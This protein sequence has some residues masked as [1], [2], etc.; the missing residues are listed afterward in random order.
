VDRPDLLGS[1]LTAIEEADL[2]ALDTETT[3][4][5]PQSDRVRLLSLGLPTNDGR[6]FACLI[7]AFAVDPSPVVA[8]LQDKEIVGHNLLFDLAF[9]ANIGF[10]PSGKL[11][12][13]MTLS[14]TLYAGLRE[15]HGLKE[16]L[17][18]ELEVEL[19][20]EMQAADWSAPLTEEHLS[21]AA[22]DVLHLPDLLAALTKKIGEAGLERTAEIEGRCLPAVCWMGSH[23][24]AIDRAAWRALAEGAEAD[25]ARLKREMAE[26]APVRPGEMFA[27]WG[28]DSA[29]DTKAMFQALGFAVEDTAD[30]TLAKIDHPIAAKLRDYRAATK[31]TGTYGRAWTKHISADGRVYP[32]WN[33]TGSEA[34]R[35]S[36]A[37]P[38]LQQIPRDRAYRRCV[39][40]PPGRVLIK[41][42]Y[43]QIELRIAAKVSG[44]KALLDA[45]MRGEDVHTQTA[46]RVLGKQNVT[47]EDR[48]LAKALNFG[49]LY[50]MGTERFRENAAAEYGLDLS[51]EQA[52]RYRDAFF[53]AYPGL[54]AWH[55]S[56]GR[57]GDAA[58][59]TRTL[60]R[61]RRVG[62]T[63][64]T[65]KLNTPVQGTGADG[66]KLAL[67][68]L[69]E[70]RDQAPGASPVLAVHDEIVVEAD[71]GRADAAAAWLK[72]AM[73]DA[74]APL[75]APVP[76]EIEV[77]VART[78][79]G[80]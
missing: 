19:S 23:G 8:A 17:N 55:R 9:L 78:W 57:T 80:D 25:A 38:N 37:D 50:G 14:R 6:F 71:E 73:V 79:A 70:R 33:Q 42:D 1:V 51:E 31:R 52:G 62:V 77:Q 13:T 64:F 75:I 58:I 69:W 47:K 20:K 45:Y 56:V 41:A 34:G 12:C 66:L 10:A 65:E 74:M 67:A 11:S 28:W 48:Q 72:A 21:Y 26:L 46:R 53:R 27:S 30:E 16:C 22:R 4:L 59:D 49:L 60:A 44:D 15:K 5:K 2:V 39:M 18:R 61:R 76:V 3:G 43:S 36:C 24:V 63:R 32:R 40:A 7:D 68:L 54:R 35:M 29:Q